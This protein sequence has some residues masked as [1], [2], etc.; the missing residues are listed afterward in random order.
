VALGFILFWL[1]FWTLGG[2][3][4][5]R[6]VVH[7]LRGRERVA[8]DATGVQCR[9]PLAPG[10][11]TR[12]IPR[13]NIRRLWLAPRGGALI[14]DT[15]RGRV[16][17]A[18]LGAREHRLALRDALRGALGLE[19]P[20]EGGPLELPR[21]WES[22][23]A[24]DGTEVLT[25]DRR[26]LARQSGTCWAAS[27]LLAL[28]ACGFAAVHAAGEGGD[29]G[30]LVVAGIAGVFSVALA[31]G[32]L[33]TGFFRSEWRVRSQALE[34]RLGSRGS[35]LRFDAPLLRL[36]SGSDSDGDPWFHLVVQGA[37]RR[38]VIASSLHDPT[39]PLQLGRW[40]ASRTGVRFTNDAESRAA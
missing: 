7:V 17:L 1:V 37:D 30:P 11:R 8:F 2:L 34:R 4:A 23:R 24:E 5:M 39:V 36:E 19:P 14:A 13:E 3:L 40:L 15:T 21:G 10:G 29:P 35:T 27:A 12:W 9:S 6:Q 28:G 22:N 26:V 31:A 33:F 38:A 16:T 32:A 25:R 20:G 18:T